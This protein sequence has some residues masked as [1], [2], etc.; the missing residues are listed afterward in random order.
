MV[1]L[2]VVT[3]A[4]VTG[5][6]VTGAG[7]TAA[8]EPREGG[9][10]GGRGAG[11]AAGTVL[12]PIGDAVL[13][14]G[15][16]LNATVPL[17]TADPVTSAPPPNPSTLLLVNVAAPPPAFQNATPLPLSLMIVLSLIDTELLARIMP[18]SP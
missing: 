10:G 5:A 13:R 11:G 12:A 7:V 15:R 3:G 4:G 1:V 16:A 2:G 6:G 17:C 9:G 8:W 18:S 14:A